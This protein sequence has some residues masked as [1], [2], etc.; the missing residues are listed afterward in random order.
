[1]NGDFGHRRQHTVSLYFDETGNDPSRFPREH[2]TTMETTM[3]YS[4]LRRLADE[5]SFNRFHGGVLFW[6]A[7]I[8][9]LDGY[10][11]SLIHI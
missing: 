2:I 10:D 7:L 8:L 6:G 4:E 1:M 5:S 9:I 3:H 11:L